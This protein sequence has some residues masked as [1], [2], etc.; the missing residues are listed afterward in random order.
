MV[1]L[2]DLDASHT[3]IKKLPDSFGLLKSLRRLRC[4]SYENIFGS[5]IGFIRRPTISGLCSL[6]DLWVHDC[7]LCDEDIVGIGSLSE[8]YGFGKEIAIVLP[9]WKIPDW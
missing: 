9:R 7:S 6:Q 2:R 3:S 8:K 1:C 4:Y 5:Q